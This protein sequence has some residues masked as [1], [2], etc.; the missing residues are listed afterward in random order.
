MGA[1]KQ[2]ACGRARCY[3]G[4]FLA[5]IPARNEKGLPQLTVTT[6]LKCRGDS[7]RTSELLNPIQ[8]AVAGKI[9]RTDGFST[10]KSHTFH[11]LHA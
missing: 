4:A 3:F 5:S 10:Y 8:A 9:A 1:S 11:N 7:I 2:A 6:S